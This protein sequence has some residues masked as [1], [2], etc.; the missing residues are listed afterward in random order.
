MAHP[1]HHA[2]S[3]AMKWGGEPSDYLPIHQWFDE[4]KRLMGDFRHR[5]LR[6]HAEGIFLCESI[7]GVTIRSASGRVV[8]TRWVAEQH[9]MEDLGRIPSASDW[10]S[11]IHPEPWMARSRK[12]SQEI[13]EQTLPEMEDQPWPTS[14]VGTASLDT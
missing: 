14:N 4:S 13:E 6:H 11:C 1:W 9:V 10:L 8:P 2:I 12:L 3:S 7:F 5:A